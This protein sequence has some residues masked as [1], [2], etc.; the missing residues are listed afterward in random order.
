MKI[1]L[2]LLLTAIQLSVF[3]QAK[4]DYVVSILDSNEAVALLQKAQENIEKYNYKDSYPLIFKAIGKD[5]TLHQSYDLLFKASVLTNNYSDSIIG[6]FKEGR[7]IFSEDDEMCY[8][9]AEIYRLKNNYKSAIDEYT[10]AL[11]HSTKLETR[12]VALP[13]FYSG[14]AFCYFKLSNYQLAI[15][16]Y[17]EYLK[18]NPSDSKILLNRGVCYSNSGNKQPAIIDLKKS[19]ELGNKTAI[20]FLKKIQQKK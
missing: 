20:E 6:Y 12:S 3:P 7:K 13:S 5:S 19:A 1:I 14:R 9:I 17:T 4:R 18:F 2:I 11:E 16:D 8:F 10:R 15:K